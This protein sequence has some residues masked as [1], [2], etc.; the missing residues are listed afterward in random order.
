MP[1]SAPM[2]EALLHDLTAH[3]GPTVTTTVAVASWAYDEV[4][5]SRRVRDLVS[6]YL[7][8]LDSPAPDYTLRRLL[9]DRL[10]REVAI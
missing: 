4:V 6:E 9:R 10:R 1:E 2:E 3:E 8:E 7:A 5:R